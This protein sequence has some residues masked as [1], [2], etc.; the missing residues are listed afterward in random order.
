MKKFVFAL[1]FF[2]LG[3]IVAQM[4]STG[5][6]QPARQ[7]ISDPAPKATGL[8]EP[9]AARPT[10]ALPEDEVRFITTIEAARARYAAGANDMAKGAARPARARD[11]CASMR[12]LSIANWIGTVHTLSTNGDGRGVLAIA[13][14]KDLLVKTWNNS[15][16]NVSD[17]TLIEPN[18]S[19][20]ARAV[21][22]RPGQRVMFA[23]HF[24]R[25]D[26]DCFRE[27][28]MTMDGSLRSP[29]FI[30]RFVDVEAM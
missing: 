12:T 18:S 19:L 26:T 17:K 14:A 21:T 30:F 13:L 29:E 25:S 11:L 9:A 2:L 16:S 1:T 6:N 22:L 27:S 5:G 3:I 20:F 8:A 24:V 7:G 10:V 23:G 4:V 15:F 28:S